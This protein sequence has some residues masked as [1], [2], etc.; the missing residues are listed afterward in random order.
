VFIPPGP[1]RFR[2]IEDDHVS[3][4]FDGPDESV[5]DDEGRNVTSDQDRIVLE[6]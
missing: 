6:D 2:V 1:K 5:I 4:P 3:D